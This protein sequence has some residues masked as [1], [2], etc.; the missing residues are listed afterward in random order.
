MKLG[1]ALRSMGQEANATLL[2][3]CVHAAERAGLAD[4]WIQ[5]H[6]AIPPDDAEGSGGRYLD[7]LTTLA[8]LAARSETIGLGVGVLNLPYRAPLPTAKALATVQ[9]LSGGRLRLGVGVGWMKAEFQALGVPRSRRGR[10]TDETLAFIRRAFEGEDGGDE[11]EAHGQRFLF[12]PRPERPP[13]FIGGAPPHA[14]ER[15]VAYGDGWLPMV[16]DP[17]TLREPV[18][19]LRELAERVGRPNPQVKAMTALPLDEP[20]RARE[21]LGLLAE[22]GVSSLVVGIRYASAAEFEDLAGRLAALDS[23]V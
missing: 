18:E 17:E 5:D 7:P 6:L 13:I 22:V 15:T 9:E 10:L 23:D 12:L 3:E 1:I 4:V 21:R 16:R 8:F 11:M 14:L 19:R 2:T 20:G